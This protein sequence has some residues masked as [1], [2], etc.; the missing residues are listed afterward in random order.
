MEVDTII[1]YIVFNIFLKYSGVSK[2]IKEFQPYYDLW[3]T[4]SDWIKWNESWMNDSLLKIESE[5][6]E[7]NVNDSVKT[8]QRCVKLFKDSPGRYTVWGRNLVHISILM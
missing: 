3:T 7:R 5:E 2:M 6:L 4:V 1:A 8:M